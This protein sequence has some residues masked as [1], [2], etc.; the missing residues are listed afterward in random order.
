MGHLFDFRRRAKVDIWGCKKERKLH[1]QSG[2][3][4]LLQIT[5]ISAFVKVDFD[6]MLRQG[7]S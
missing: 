5:A 7:T 2:R 3:C 4:L 1:E 6:D